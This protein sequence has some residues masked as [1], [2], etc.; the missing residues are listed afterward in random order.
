MIA[1]K[2][3][4]LPALAKAHYERL[5]VREK[6]SKLKLLEKYLTDLHANYPPASYQYNFIEMLITDIKMKANDPES[7]ILTCTPKYL[8]SK[9]TFYN[10]S[11]PL[12]AQDNDLLEKLSKCFYYSQY[13]KWGAYKLAEDLSVNVCPYC[14]RSYTFTIGNDLSKG[15]RPQFDHYINKAAAPYFSLSFFNLI[16]SCYVCNSGF[17]KDKMLNIIS[18][19]HPY[20]DD[21]TDDVVFTI[22]AKNINFINGISDAYS[23][24]LIPDSQSKLSAS[25]L[26]RITD[27]YDVFRLAELYQK[28]KDYVN[29]LIQKAVVFTPSHIHAVY[30]QFRG[31]LFK[32]PEDTKK[33]LLGNYFMLDELEKRPLAKLS[34]DISN[35]LEKLSSPKP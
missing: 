28:H 10:V 13:E 14:N 19:I 16:P 2:R 32:K 18:Y 8:Q 25:E 30:N 9:Y 34:R 3:N 17:K 6:G 12:L 23:L 33:M 4:N 5:M 20:L 27:T 35:E 26:K 31:T 7:S 24:E 22:G 21:Y 15:T 1:I 29:E 11:F